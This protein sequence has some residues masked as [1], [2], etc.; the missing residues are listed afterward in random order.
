[1]PRFEVHVWTCYHQTYIVEARDEDEA[2]EKV[3]G[4]NLKPAEEECFDFDIFE[5]CQIDDA[6]DTSFWRGT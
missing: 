4:G 1:M 6:N 2:R 5:M 3:Y